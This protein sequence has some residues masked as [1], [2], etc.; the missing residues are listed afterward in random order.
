M[1]SEPDQSSL[2]SVLHDVTDFCRLVFLR[3][4]ELATE[5]QSLAIG[6]GSAPLSRRGTASVAQWLR[7]L[8]RLPIDLI[9]AAKG[10]QQS[11]DAARG[12]AAGLGVEVVEDERLRDQ[13]MGAWQGRDWQALVDQEG[14]AVSDF[15]QNIGEVVPPEG[16]S[17][18]QAVERMF[19]W[20]Y[21]IREEGLGKTWAV[22]TSGS[23]ITGFA[24]AMLGM[25]LSRCVSLNLPHGGIG[26]L[27][28]F[29]NGARIATWRPG[30]LSES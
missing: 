7:D 28:C 18:G 29:A 30:A 5:H 10:Q 16:E 26:I 24:A 1:T 13:G 4:P 23:M 3:T 15:F 19:D 22:V 9:H 21:G 14:P 8:Q 20:W 17:L 6:S 12:L 25:R 11:V 27:D 2:F